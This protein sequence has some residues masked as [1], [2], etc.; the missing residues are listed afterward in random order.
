MKNLKE[1]NGKPL[2]YWTLSAALSSKNIDA[3]VVSSE[4]P[5][6]LKYSSSLGALTHRRPMELAQ[7]DSTTES[8][9]L[10]ALENNEALASSELIVL[11]QATSPLTTSEDLDDAIDL[12]SVSNIDS[13]LSA[14][15]SHHFLWR[16]D[17]N[18]LAKPVNYQPMNRPM[19]Q[20]ISEFFRE[21]GAFYVTKKNIW[22][23]QKCRL[24]GNIGI[25]IMGEKHSIELD[26]EIDW[27]NLEILAAEED[28]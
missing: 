20:D 15:Q 13:M 5:Q 6:I 9:V 19:R 22:D 10:D 3:L 24:G 23:K 28:I 25:Y 27:L 4:D 16:R 21:N 1:F 18:G 14:V 12:F 7:D 11:I 26:T 17:T 8:A 2:L